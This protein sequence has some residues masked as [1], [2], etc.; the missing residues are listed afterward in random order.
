MIKNFAAPIRTAF[1]Y[2]MSLLRKHGPIWQHFGCG[3]ITTWIR[4]RSEIPVWIPPCARLHGVIRL[5]I[6]CRRTYS[7]TN[8]SNQTGL[9]HICTNWSTVGCNGLCRCKPTTTESR[10]HWHI[11]VCN[12]HSRLQ[13]QS[14]AIVYYHEIAGYTQLVGFVL[15]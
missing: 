2:V 1:E 11:L 9:I 13:S 10:W 6:Y 5:R 8:N 3:R 15:F 12:G 7:D 4:L 14:M